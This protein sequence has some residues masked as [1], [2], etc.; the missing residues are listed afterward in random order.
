MT[1]SSPQPFKEG[2]PVPALIWSTFEDALRANIKRLAKDIATTLGQSEAPLLSALL[3]GGGTV[4]GAA[5]IR[6]YIFEEAEDNREADMR[7]KFLCQRPD[8]P[9]FIQACGQPVVWSAAAP[10]C[11]RCAEHL[12][13]KPSK[14]KVYLHTLKPLDTSHIDDVV[15]ADKRLFYDKDGTV[16]NIENAAVGRYSSEK[17][18]LTLFEVDADTVAPASPC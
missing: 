4:A 2:V 5:A 3:K 1:S 9:L 18:R 6:P 16:Y 11:S 8:A 12:Y 10:S 13:S 7:C 17:K 15:P 14:L